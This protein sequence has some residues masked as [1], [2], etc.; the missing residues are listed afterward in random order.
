M[1]A[2]EVSSGSHKVMNRLG[3]F[4]KCHDF[5]TMSRLGTIKKALGQ[6]VLNPPDLDNF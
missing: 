6:I 1:S 3:S 5:G 2:H 4:H